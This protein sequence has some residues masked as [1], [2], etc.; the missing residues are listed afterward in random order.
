MLIWSVKAESLCGIIIPLENQPRSRVCP[1]A[2][3]NAYVNLHSRVIN[4]CPYQAMSNMDTENEIVCGADIH[5][6]FLVATIISRSGLKLQERFNM[7]Q[8]GLLAFKTW[9]LDNKCQKVA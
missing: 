6:D 3:L 2:S 7:N 8:D 4:I 5:R 9:V 1:N